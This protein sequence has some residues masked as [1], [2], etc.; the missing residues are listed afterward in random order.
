MRVKGGLVDV[1]ISL[2]ARGE[3]E[4]CVKI[5]VLEFIES[6]VHTRKW[7]SVVTCNLIKA[8]V[9]NAHE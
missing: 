7:A 2:E 1:F 6:V 8:T 4:M 9:V 5:R 3:V